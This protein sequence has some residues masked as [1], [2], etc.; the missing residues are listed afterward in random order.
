MVR[1]QKLHLPTRDPALMLTMTMTMA[2]DPLSPWMV[3]MRAQRH[4]GQV[5][6]SFSAC[7]LGQQP[8]NTSKAYCELR[9]HRRC[10]PSPM[11]QPMS[12]HWRALI[13]DLQHESGLTTT[14]AWSG[15]RNTTL[16]FAAGAQEAQAGPQSRQEAQPAEIRDPYKPLNPHSAGDLPL[17][18]FRKSKP[19]R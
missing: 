19:R 5:C 8:P 1:I 3:H 13:G 17:R 18:P 6:A 7:W 10:L 11:Q 2:P 4:A 14:S 15:I 16:S 12:L 9:A